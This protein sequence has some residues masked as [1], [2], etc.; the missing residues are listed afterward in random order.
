[1]KMNM[2]FEEL[3]DFFDDELTEYFKGSLEL[4]SVEEK[5]YLPLVDEFNQLVYLPTPV[6]NIR[7]MLK[8]WE[9]VVKA[10]FSASHIIRDGEVFL[11]V[12]WYDRENF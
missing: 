9:L 4:G 2:N 8:L 11:C 5:S 10:D 6:G 3:K 7:W 1:M 12:D